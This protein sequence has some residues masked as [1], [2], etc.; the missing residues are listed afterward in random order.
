MALDAQ[1]VEAL[2]NQT[3]TDWT[4]FDQQLQERS[5]WDA[6]RFAFDSKLYVRFYMKPRLNAEKSAE[7]N[8]AIYEDTVY[9]EIMAP[10]EKNS[11]IQR[12]AWEQDFVRFAEHYK[13]FQAGVAEQEVG[14]PL[15]ALPFLSESQIE[16][17]AYFKVRTVEKLAN[18]SD[19]VMQNFM[20]AR[21]LSQKAQRFLAAI[22]SN[23][24]IAAENRTLKARLD[25]LEK[26][27][28]QRTEPAPA[29]QG[30]DILT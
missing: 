20:G 17:L 12:P 24:A 4:R 7:A 21:E 6:N 23:E 2:Q 16:E 11:I 3:P 10:G 29:A 25:A 30:E 26:L 18:L 22:N 27:L 28:E 14:T 13:Q 8:R 15:K 9:V 19:A 1:Q 5:N